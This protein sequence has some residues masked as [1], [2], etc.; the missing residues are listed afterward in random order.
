MPVE[1]PDNTWTEV[2]DEIAEV[3]PL[4]PKFVEW[5]EIAADDPDKIEK[6]RRHVF[7][8]E[9]GESLTGET[10]TVDSLNELGAWMIVSSANQNGFRFDR[11]TADGF[12][13]T[14]NLMLYA[15]KPVA[16]EDA[17]AD[18]EAQANR[19]NI[20]RKF[21]NRIG[22]ILREL[23]QYLNDNGGTWI[24]SVEIV[25]GPYQ[26]AE[27]EW[28][29]IGRRQGIEIAVAWGVLGSGGSAGG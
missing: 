23:A 1:A 21:K 20:D 2:E 28:A 16:P 4:L 11:T 26:N 29:T 12:S 19:E 15:G 14:G 3:L 8:D 25:D 6:A 13:A 5:C 7:L 24:R 9:I 10:W 18:E 22:T 27:E 17:S